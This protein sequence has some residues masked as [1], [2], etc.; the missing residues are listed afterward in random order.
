M[1]IIASPAPP[2]VKTFHLQVEDVDV[3]C[4]LG[5]HHF[6]VGS[7]RVVDVV[8]NPGPALPLHHRDQ[9][10]RRGPRQQ[11][12]PARGRGRRGRHQDRLCRIERLQ[13]RGHGQARRYPGHCRGARRPDQGNPQP[14]SHPH[15]GSRLLRFGQLHDGG[16]GRRHR[17][18]AGRPGGQDRP[19]PRE[20]GPCGRERPPGQDQPPPGRLG[21]V[22]GGG[23]PA[24]RFPPQIRPGG[25]GLR[26]HHGPRATS[27]PAFPAADAAQDAFPPTPGLRPGARTPSSASGDR[28][29]RPD[30][31]AG[32]CIRASRRPG[33]PP[34]PRHPAPGRKTAPPTD[35]ACQRQ[36][37]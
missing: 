16:P 20:K 19:A 5:F 28:T 13:H 37:G 31:R 12:P 25:Q 29:P 33:T 8:E 11:Q 17:V 10:P 18:P 6:P 15:P 2:S 7:Q 36:P 30:R 22:R 26:A 3:V 23:H 24:G 21:P 14:R 34:P 4:H 35:A 27:A 9:P 32:A 1:I